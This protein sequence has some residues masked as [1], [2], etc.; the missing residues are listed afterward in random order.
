MPF[1]LFLYLR[2]LLYLMRNDKH[3]TYYFKKI[4]PKSKYSGHFSEHSLGSVEKRYQPICY[5]DGSL[6]NICSQFAFNKK[7][8]QY[9][10]HLSCSY[11]IHI[12]E[13]FKR[14]YHKDL[15]NSSHANCPFTIAEP[16]M[17]SPHIFRSS[18]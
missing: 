16:S 5:S 13:F 12:T 17:Q 18:A 1:F 14:S 11:H 15:R 8:N 3:Q 10:K 9:Y 4:A 6:P 2:D 7:Q